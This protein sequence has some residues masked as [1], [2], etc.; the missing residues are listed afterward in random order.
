MPGYREMAVTATA[1]A[2]AAFLDRAWQTIAAAARAAKVAAV[3]GTERVVDGVRATALV[4][5]RDGSVLGFQDKVQLDPSEDDTYQPGSG[6]RVFAVDG[7]TFGIAIC[8][9]GWRYPET[10][11]HAARLARSWCSI[12]T[13]TRRSW[14]ASSR[15]R[16]PTRATR[17]T[18]RR[19]CTY[20]AD[21]A[22]TSR[23][24]T[25]RGRGLAGQ[26]PWSSTPTASS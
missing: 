12:P 26:P 16:S 15:P 14:A 9:E 19:R 6:R 8:H 23:P 11:R 18:R 25:P 24:S 4:I 20:A 2:D 10:V 17:S 13:T 21:L 1:A 22:A 5:D 3:V 7:L